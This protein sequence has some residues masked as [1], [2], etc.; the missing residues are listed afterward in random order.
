MLEKY[1]VR[2]DLAVENREK[3]EKDNVEISGVVLH[4]SEDRE[5]EITTTAV[6][7]ETDSGARAMGK[8]KGIYITLEAPNLKVPDRGIH[9]EVSKKLAEQLKKLLP[10]KRDSVLVAGLGNRNITPDALGPCAADHLRVTRHIIREYGERALGDEKTPMIS[11]VVPGVMAQT[12][13]ETLEILRGV[14]REIKP[15]VVL[16]IDALAARSTKR[17]NCTIQLTDTGICPGSGVGNYRCGLNAETLGVPVIGI[18]IPTVVDAGTIVHDAVAELLESLEDAEIDEFLSELVSPSL[19][20]MFVTPKDIDDT[21]S[22]LSFTLSEGIN[23][24]L[25]F[26]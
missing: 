18:G 16:L 11:A 12:G 21:I 3:F 25:T 15:D 4:R 8:P 5:R 14:V 17:L 10:R 2:T 22:R 13:M 19:R 23:L 26:R 9:R 20:E 6:K 7:I 1:R 24:A